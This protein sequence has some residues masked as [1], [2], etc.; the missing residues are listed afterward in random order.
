MTWIIRTVT[1]RVSWRTLLIYGRNI[2]HWDCVFRHGYKYTK[3]QDSAILDVKTHQRKLSCVHI[4]PFVTHKVLKWRICQRW[5]LPNSS[6]ATFKESISN[7]K[8]AW[9]TE[10]THTIWKKSCYQKYDPRR[11]TLLK[12]NNDEEKDYMAFRDTILTLS[13]YYKRSSDEKVGS[14][15]KPITTLPNV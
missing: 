12:Q 3:A 7:V 2:W 8:N 14:H 10:A 5:S 6:D 1:V 4:S 13:V 9:W 15:T 11:S